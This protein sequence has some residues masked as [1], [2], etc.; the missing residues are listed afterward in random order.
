MN[1]RSQVWAL[2]RLRWTLVRSPYVRIGLLT[3]AALV[4]YLGFL[5]L[6][7][8]SQI[9]KDALAA[10]VGAAPAALLGFGVL[11]VVAPLT[12][13]V[14]ELV[15]SD[16]LVAYPVRPATQFVSSL[17]LAPINLVWFVQ[18]LVLTAETGYLT[19]GSPHLA[20]AGLTS[21][22]FVLACTCA[23]QALAWAVTG[24]CHNRRGRLAMRSTAVVVA[25]AAVLV[26]RTGHGG[27]VVD[28]S[29]GP[30]VADALRAGGRGDV[31]GWLPVTAALALAAVLALWLGVLACRWALRLP[32]DRGAE[33]TSREVRRRRTPDTAYQA[34]VATDRASVWRAPALR[35]GALVLAIMPGVAAAGVGLPWKSLVF[36]PGLV[37]A[38]GGLLFGFNAFC[39]DGSGAVWVA[40]MPHSPGLVA[41][42]KARV[43]GEA[44]LLGAT[45]AAVIGSMRATG[46]PTL[47]QAMAMVSS[48]LGCSALV[49]ALCLSL[50]VRKPYRADLNG[51]RDSVAPPGALVLTSARLVFPAAVVA[52][53]LEV[54]AASP[55]WWLPVALALGVTLLS[56]AS[57]SRTLRRYDEPL[58]RSRIVQVV[59]AG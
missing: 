6:L 42:A 55:H 27:D 7:T 14:S 54:A 35:R 40:S 57:I 15:P 16:Q 34:L 44:V 13:G 10:A 46:L 2:V 53:I 52:G 23:G 8:R 58:L 36:L 43:T 51:P 28:Q 5:A 50:A 9:D 49:V 31:G 29:F 45:L 1:A 48:V 4:P 39:L 56:S 25:L 38:G 20:W 26:V 12:G 33:R 3:S 47:T 24:L 41:R 59:S 21:L 18:I 19:L 37:A 22:L 11:A 30:T 32:P 17:I